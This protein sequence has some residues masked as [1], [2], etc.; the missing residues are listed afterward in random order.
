MCIGGG[1]RLGIW[2]VRVLKDFMLYWIVNLRIR[3][4]KFSYLIC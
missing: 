3:S 4:K 1:G 2:F